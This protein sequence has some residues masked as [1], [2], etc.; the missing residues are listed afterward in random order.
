[1]LLFQ[2]T[3]RH[4]YFLGKKRPGFHSS[5]RHLASIFIFIVNCPVS[6]H[7][8]AVIALI[9]LFL[10]F[11]APNQ[12]GSILIGM[13]IIL[14]YLNSGAAVYVALCFELF[15]GGLQ[16]ILNVISSI[17]MVTEGASSKTDI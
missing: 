2:R 3:Q 5:E 7:N 4:S 9:V 8:V 11:G 16:N 6:W 17:V 1:M 13:L 10:S 15:C 12:P 14:T